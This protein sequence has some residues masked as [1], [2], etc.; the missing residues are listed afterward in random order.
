MILSAVSVLV[1]A[2]LS[3]GVP[4][5]L[6]NCP[7][8]VRVASVTFTMSCVPRYVSGLW[9]VLRSSRFTYNRR[10]MQYGERAFVLI[11]QLAGTAQGE[12]SIEYC[13]SVIYILQTNCNSAPSQSVHIWRTTS[14]CPWNCLRPLERWDRGFESH[15][16]NGCLCLF[17][18][19]R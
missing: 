2:L 15:W 8:W 16:R 17:C 12:R 5:V 19:Y 3:S 13:S 18:L 1:V 4:E 14:W 7:V 10:W 11:S 9:S 6:M